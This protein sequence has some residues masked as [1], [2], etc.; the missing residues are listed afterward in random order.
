MKARAAAPPRTPPRG[1]ARRQARRTGQ[2]ETSSLEKR[3][4]DRTPRRFGE[5]LR[6]ALPAWVAARLLVGLSFV[7][8]RILVDRLGLE[9][10]GRRFLADGLLGWDGQWYVRIAARGYEA[11]PLQG[12]RFFPLLSLLARALAPLLGGRHDLAV[13]LL[14]NLSALVFAAL[15]HRLCRLEGRSEDFARRATWLAAFTPAAFVLT[16][17]YSEGL[18]GALAVGSFLALRR[19]RWWLAGSLGVLAGLTRPI[20]IL[21]V[22]PAFFEAGRAFRRATLRVRLAGLASIAGP[23]IGLG[24]YLAWVAKRFGDPLLPFSLQQDA[25]LRGPLASPLAV[26]AD[27]LERLVHGQ[28]DRNGLPAIW[29]LV[30]FGLMVA[31]W[32]NWPAPYLLLAATTLLVALSTTRLG[33]FERYTFGT[34]P[35]VLALTSVTGDPRVE[36]GTLILLGAAMLGYSTLAF[37]GLYVP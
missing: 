6:A 12:L 24:L 32:R 34:F 31:L 26:L 11:L 18:L 28:L 23:G 2:V 36:R 21:L 30:L 29:I 5:D 14:A 35:V 1:Q 3:Q 17:G 7:L 19:G 25:R 33:S 13:L 10:A 8:A 37:L 4:I 22:L 20:G 9:E 15:L 16:W 27:A